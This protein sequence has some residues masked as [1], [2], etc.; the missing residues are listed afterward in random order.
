LPVTTAA[1]ATRATATRSAGPAEG[2]WT[3]TVTATDD[4]GQASEMTQSF[5]VNTTIGFL[6]TAPKKLFLPP[7]G[8][9]I[10][11]RWKQSK[12]ASVVVTVETRTGEVVR[13]LA[14]RRYDAGAQGVTWNGLDRTRKAV[15]GGVYV[16][17]VVG[18]NP[19]GTLDLSRGLRVQRIVGH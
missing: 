15:K 8:R 6:T 4:I 3:L 2:R 1:S 10:R 5:V 17:R 9:D 13:T 11:I 7:G 19:L 18:R 12:S 14:R 16:V